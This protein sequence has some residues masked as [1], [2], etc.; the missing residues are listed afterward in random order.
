MP[1]TQKRAAR[2]GANLMIFSGRVTREELLQQFG[3]IDEADPAS[4]D[5]WLIVD[6]QNTN[7]TDLDLAALSELKTILGPKMMVMKARR[8]FDVAIVC[9]WDFNAPIYLTWKSFVAQDEGYPS[10]PMFFSN[11]QAAC[12]RLGYEGADYAEVFDL[13]TGAS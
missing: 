5:N 6:N 13:C 7:N 8:P 9:Q 4:S 11:L 1:V 2:S 10:A 12:S 3:G